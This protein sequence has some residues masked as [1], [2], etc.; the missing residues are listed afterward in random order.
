MTLEICSTMYDD[1]AAMAL[2]PSGNYLL[3]SFANAVQFFNIYPR[4]LE[5]YHEL[6]INACNE[7]K[8]TTQGHL[9]A[10]Q[11]R[12]EVHVYR[13]FTAELPSNYIFAW[14]S[15]SVKSIT[16]NEDDTGFVT[17]A[18]DNSIAVW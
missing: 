3:A 11:N 13:F 10:I 18:I 6:S 7:I 8:F 12:G 5:K 16:W 17:T 14:H 4:R 9:V 2:H 1:V 15:G